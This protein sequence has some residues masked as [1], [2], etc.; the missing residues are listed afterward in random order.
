MRNWRPCGHCPT[1]I[2]VDALGTAFHSY[3][4][5]YFQVIHNVQGAMT[6]TTDVVRALTGHDARSFAEFARDHSTVFKGGG[7]SDTGI[8]SPAGASAM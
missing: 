3:Q 8:S 2:L 6:E 1:R 5:T 7:I 4:D